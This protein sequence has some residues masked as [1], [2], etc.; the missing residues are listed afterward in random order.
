VGVVVVVV[1]G[2]FLLQSYDP[3]KKGLSYYLISP[4][5]KGESFYSIF[6]SSHLLDLINHQ[7]LVSPVGL[8][9]LLTSVLIFS[10]KINYKDS[11]FRFL[12]LL[13]IFSLAFAFFI[14]PKLGYPRDW[15]MFAFSA[16]GYTYLGVYIFLKSWREAKMGNLRYVTISLLFTSLISTAPWIYVNASEKKSV[17]RF[18]HL[19]DLDKGRIGS[20]RENL[21]MYYDSRGEW[22]KEIQ[23]WEKGIA[24]TGNARYITNLGVI[25][26]NQQKYDLALKELER[27]LKADSTFASTHFYLGKIYA[28]TKEYEEAIT[29][30]RKAIKFGPDVTEYYDNLG[31]LLAHQERYQEAIEVFKEGVKATPKYPS[32]Y[33]N[34]GYSYFNLGDL[35]SAE[36]YLQLYLEYSPQAEDAS[37]VKQVLRDLS[38]KRLQAPQP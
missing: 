2:L 32:I 8:L 38:Q 33:R 9:I 28:Q 23:Q 10:K 4:L 16:L 5:G 13:S 6:S 34:L 35:I 1:V 15:D 14:D 17:E 12:L 31:A 3:D 26:Y 25:Y 29:E 19:L 24:V 18:E 7:L 30:Y 11:M 37:E 36:K 27:S 20:G 22:E 21:A